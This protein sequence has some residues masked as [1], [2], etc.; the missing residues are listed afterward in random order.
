MEHHGRRGEQRAKPRWGNA[1]VPPPKPKTYARDLTRLPRALVP[2]TQKKRWVLWRWELRNDKTGKWKWTKPPLQPNGTYASSNNPKTWSTH[3]DV[4][5]AFE[6]IK[7]DGI[8]YMLGSG[9][10]K[11]TIQGRRRGRQRQGNFAPACRSGL[12]C[13]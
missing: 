1:P 2:L 10:I 5:D 8:G 12:R 6:S 7:A 13:A 11:S 4:L 9:L 3:A